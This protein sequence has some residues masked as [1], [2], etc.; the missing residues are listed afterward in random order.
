MI[1]ASC[2]PCLFFL[3]T[4]YAKGFP[5]GSVVKNLPTMQEMQ[6]QSG[7]GRALAERNGNPLQYSCVGNPMDRGA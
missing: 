7:L 1:S 4:P 3:I 5:G 6:V 2:I